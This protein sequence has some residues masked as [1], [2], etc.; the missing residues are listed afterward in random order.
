MSYVTTAVIMVSI[1]N[2]LAALA[3]QVGQ[4]ASVGEGE[5]S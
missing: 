2:V 5:G 3:E 1:G 4:V